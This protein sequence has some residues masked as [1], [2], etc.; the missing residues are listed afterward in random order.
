M[1]K[2]EKAKVEDLKNS[3]VPASLYWSIEQVCEY[4]ENTLKL[5]EYTVRK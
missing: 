5:P 4:F 1:E 2:F 3:E